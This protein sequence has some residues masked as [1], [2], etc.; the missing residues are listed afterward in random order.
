[1]VGL[2]G[3][4][5]GIG[6]VSRKRGEELDVLDNQDNVYTYRLVAYPSERYR[7]PHS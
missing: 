2:S 5:W 6:M 1:M 3:V 4:G 7:A